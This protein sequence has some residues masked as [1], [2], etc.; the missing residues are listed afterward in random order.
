VR[1][2]VI[3]PFVDRKHGTERAVAE[4]AERLAQQYG[5]T[6]DLYSQRVAD[7]Q[8][9][10]P[11]SAVRDSTGAV[12]WHQI[13]RLPG[14][15]ILQFPAWLLRNQQ[16]RKRSQRSTGRAS[17]V[18][19]S[20]GINAFDADVI[21]VHAVFHRLAE[22]QSG[23]E[24]VGP[25]AVHR[26][27]Y[28]SLLCVL[29]RR[30]YTDPHVTLAAVS[31]HTAEQLARYFGRRDVVLIPNGVDPRHFSAAAIASLRR[32]AR[33]ERH[34]S[35]QEFVLLLVGNDWRNKGLTALLKAM[36][37]LTDPKLRLLVA[38]QDEPGPFRREIEQLNLLGCVDFSSPVDDVRSFYAA[39]DMLVAPSLEDSF[40]LP[41]L[42][43]MACGLPC[44][45]SPRAGISAWLTPGVDAVL[46]R[47]PESSSELAATIRAVVSDPGL[48]RTLAHNAVTT[49]TKLSWDEHAAK[50]RAL[51]ESA[52]VKKKTRAGC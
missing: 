23:R 47:D 14:P 31:R 13:T 12:C 21:L 40:S 6:V 25:R 2:T 7:V 51:M 28:Y 39:A 8:T 32:A 48:R 5:D 34:Y 22:L 50:L 16:A 26:K 41:V 35:E 20:P 10:S 33:A 30:I 43:A 4:L 1:I 18:V 49:A 17:D 36:A 38:G 44:I 46:L 24:V 45:V 3:S 15:Q 19:F 11:A 29:E 37:Q 9:I 52:A 42:E 27:L